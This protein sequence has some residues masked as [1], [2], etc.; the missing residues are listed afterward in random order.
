MV[1]DMP[2]GSPQRQAFYQRAT[3]KS[4]SQLKS[5]WARMIFTGQGMPPRQV[6]SVR[7]MVRTVQQDP[8]AVGYLQE[9]EIQEGLRVLLR[10]P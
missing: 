5:Y 4:S 6:K 8:H 3:G 1:L 7:D 10:L 2:E 9:T